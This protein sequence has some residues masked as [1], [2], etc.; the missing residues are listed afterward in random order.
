[1]LFH[2]SNGPMRPLVP[3]LF[4][5]ALAA[6]RTPAAPPAAM[7]VADGAGAL[8]ATRLDPAF[9][10]AWALDGPRSTA[11]DPWNQLSL[12]IADAGAGAID[13]KRHWRGSREG[14]AFTD[15]L[16]VVPGRSARSAPMT[17]WPDNRHLGAF[18][19]GD[20]TKHV[21]TRVEDGGRTL[22]TESRLTVSVQQGEHDLRI[23]TEYRLSP[24]GDRLDVLELRSTRPRPIHYV[25]RRAD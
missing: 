25:F 20:S 14:G 13:L 3:L 7:G 16:R 4:A 10:G 23:V 19:A 5:L 24:E 11:I 9:A 22:V 2:I 15:S 17:Q 12:E 6:C 8:P 21:A 1:M 18:I